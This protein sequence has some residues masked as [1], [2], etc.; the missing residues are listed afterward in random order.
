MHF[1]FQLESLEIFPGSS[2]PSVRLSLRHPQKMDKHECGT[3]SQGRSISG[4]PKPSL[5]Q[6]LLET[7]SDNL[8]KQPS[9]GYFIIV[10]L[11]ENLVM[12]FIVEVLSIRLCFV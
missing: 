10:F 5:A 9:Y 1:S 12:I 3:Q 4:A 11:A 2:P 7:A 6:H 8:E